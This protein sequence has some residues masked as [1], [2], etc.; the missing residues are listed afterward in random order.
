MGV[1]RKG[2]KRRILYLA[3]FD[4]IPSCNNLTVLLS[5][6]MSLF[7]PGLQ[8]DLYCPA[9]HNIPLHRRQPLW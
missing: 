6:P 4:K 7:L 9:D 5:F 8:A 2:V 3:P 1:W